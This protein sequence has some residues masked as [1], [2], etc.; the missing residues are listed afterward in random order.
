MA[1]VADDAAYGSGVFAGCLRHRTL[2]PLRP[3]L[4]PSEIST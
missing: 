1:S 4:T 2:R 3:L